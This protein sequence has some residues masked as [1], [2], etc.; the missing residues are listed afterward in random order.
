MT[1]T[2]SSFLP[3]GDRMLTFEVAGAA[4]GLPI[5]VVL[6]VAETDRATC[7]P[8][9]PTS[10]A[11]VM[12]WHGDALPLVAS[13]QLLAGEGEGAEE[14]SEDTLLKAQVLVVSDRADQPAR[15]GMP[16]DRVMGLVSGEAAQSRTSSVVAER[17]SLEGRVVNVLDPRRLVARAEEL[18]EQV[19]GA[20]AAF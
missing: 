18:I 6:E 10:L 15:L 7:V 17:R 4:Y 2:G 16:V 13:D 9:L 20:P 1:R 19:A 12:N 8:G 3:T 14:A 11:A 5:S